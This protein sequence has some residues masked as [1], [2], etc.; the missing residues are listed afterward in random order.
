MFG[1]VDSM[2]DWDWFCSLQAGPPQQMM[3]HNYHQQTLL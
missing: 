1:F 3:I 2:I